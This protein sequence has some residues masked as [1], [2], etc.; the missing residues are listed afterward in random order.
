MIIMC[1]SYLGQEVVLF[2]GSH[3]SQR[4]SG[5]AAKI[6]DLHTPLCCQDYVALTK[7][8]VADATA[9]YAVQGSR[10]GLLKSRSQVGPSE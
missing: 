9:V 7:V 1:E 3:Q 5:G 4:V 2:I 6:N 10:K 8:P